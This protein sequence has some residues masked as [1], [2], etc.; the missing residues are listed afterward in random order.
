MG[1]RRWRGLILALAGLTAVSCGTRVDSQRA[2]PATSS[3]SVLPAAGAAADSGPAPTRTGGTAA[4]APLTGSAPRASGTDQPKGSGSVRSPSA[5]SATAAASA[6][7]AG[8][9]AAPVAAGPRQATPG[10]PSSPGGPAPATPATPT[11][12]KSPVVIANVGSYSG[13]AGV[14]L[15]PIMLGAQLWV[16]SINQ[17]GGLNGHHVQFIVY[18]DNTDPARHRSQV[19]EAIEQRKAVAFLTNIEGFGGNEATASYINSKGVPVI[20]SEGSA[21]YFYDF[22]M[23]FPQQSHG[24]GFFYGVVPA[25]ASQAVPQNKRRLGT[26]VCVEAQRCADGANVWAK[27]AAENGLE[28]VYQTRISLAQPDFSAVCLAARNSN[29]QSLIFMADQNTLG[30]LSASCARQNYFPLYG[31]PSAVSDERQA[32]DPNLVGMAAN[33]SLFPYFED[34]TPATHEFQEA[35]RL[36]G[37]KGFPIGNGAP[38]GW[39]AGKLLEKAGAALSEPPTSESLLKGLWSIKN[40][41]L[42]GLTLPLTFSE[43]ELPV[44]RACWFT[45]VIADKKWTSPDNFALNCRQE[46]L[47]KG[48]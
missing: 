20:G 13:P 23:F 32:S 11:G 44:R 40:D 4:T 43:H 3:P 22:P 16:N 9:A 18:D 1:P 10:V 25:L 26:V 17:R 38:M 45:T 2:A 24:A 19:Q 41:T 21:D 30:R 39:V 5:G 42:G 33:T 7:G 31:I 6:P 37:G 36:V 46:P 15:K 28:L 29:V 27:Y 8:S 34:N 48:F 14:T 35:I 12:P 47:P